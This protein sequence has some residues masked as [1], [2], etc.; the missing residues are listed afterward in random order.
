M[1]RYF[2]PFSGRAPAALDINGHRLL[3]V[4]RDQDDIE[5]SLSLFGAD[6]VKS[7]EGEFG[8]D[9]SFVA[10][11]KLAD[12]IQGDVVIAPDDEPLEAIL[13]DLQEELPWI[14]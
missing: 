13:M 2:I 10:L 8:R 5:E 7:I 6:T 1:S 3:I 11:E 4:S 12:S 14:Q 9:E